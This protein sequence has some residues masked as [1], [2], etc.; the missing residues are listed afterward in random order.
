MF[1]AITAI[2]SLLVMIIVGKKVTKRKSLAEVEKIEA[3]IDTTEIN[4]LRSIVDLWRGTAKELQEDMKDLKA[5]LLGV[6]N[7]L[8]DVRK[9][10]AEVRKE[11]IALKKE[12]VSVRKE[13]VL[14]KEQIIKLENTLQNQK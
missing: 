12:L 10:L 7:E 1:E 4:N 6:K 13:N 11:N 2:L 8:V 5:E 3:D 9:E 14:L